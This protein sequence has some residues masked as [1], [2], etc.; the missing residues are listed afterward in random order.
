MDTA[1]I[2]KQDWLRWFGN[3][4]YLHWNSHSWIEFENG[5][6]FVDAQAGSS[7]EYEQGIKAL[8]DYLGL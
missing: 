1:V 2:T 6:R 4:V 7:L 3:L 8:A 5:T